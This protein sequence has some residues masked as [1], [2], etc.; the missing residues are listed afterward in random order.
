MISTNAK[1][2]GSSNITITN[3]TTSYQQEI[4]LNPFNVTSSKKEK[5]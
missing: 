2:L 1:N 4:Q 5:A 3:N